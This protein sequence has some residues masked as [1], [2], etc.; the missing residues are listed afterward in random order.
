VESSLG[1][2]HPKLTSE[3]EQQ[4]QPRHRFFPKQVADT[5][6]KLTSSRDWDHNLDLVLIFLR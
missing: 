3:A 6:L 2:A 5:V 1:I 4:Q